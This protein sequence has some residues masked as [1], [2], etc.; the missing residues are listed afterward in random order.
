MLVLLLSGALPACGGS[1]G[2]DAAGVVSPPVTPA[3]L[4][5]EYQF[6]V[7]DAGNQSQWLKIESTFGNA[8]AQEVTID[9][10][11]EPFVGRFNYAEQSTLVQ[12]GAVAVTSTFGP[13]VVDIQEPILLISG[14]P[15]ANV[16]FAADITLEGHVD[17]SI[18]NDVVTLERPGQTP[19]TMSFRD[20]ES[21][22]SQQS[23]APLWLHQSSMAWASLHLLHS[24]VTLNANVL[25][26]I[27]RELE[28][29]GVAD[30]ACDAFDAAPPAPALAQGL[31]RL[32]WLGS[33]QFR[34]AD[35]FAWDFTSCW[36]DSDR[37]R[38]AIFDGTVRLD[39]YSTSSAAGMITR[40]GFQ[41]FD[42]APGG[43]FFENLAMDSIRENSPLVYS[44][45][46]PHS[47]I[48]SGGIRL[49]FD[50]P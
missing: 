26:N 48:L 5:P 35:R 27:D 46:V 36:L 11:I 31:S 29:N 39:G 41:S 7:S 19:V 13:I 47:F 45:Y 14:S 10:R 15:P 3:A 23:S 6:T 17:I 4:Q 37:S 33:G 40:I 9:F 18:A 21:L 24:L 2:G 44:R 20:F 16:Q 32:T 34:T 1:G 38:T 42:N 49:I 12:S 22:V 25:V 28:E 8:L 50:M 30:V 43:I